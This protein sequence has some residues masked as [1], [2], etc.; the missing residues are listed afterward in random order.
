MEQEMCVAV[1]NTSKLLL[2]QLF[3]EDSSSSSDSDDDVEIH[4]RGLHNRIEQPRRIPSRVLNFIEHTIT[5]SSAKEFQS[6]FRLTRPTYENLLQ[7]IGPRLM[8]N[9]GLPGKTRI[10]PA[11]QILSALWLLGTSES[12]R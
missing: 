9:D 11:T 3:L 2:N 7:K 1:L 4:I 10:D 6:H 5:N 8:K 12:Y